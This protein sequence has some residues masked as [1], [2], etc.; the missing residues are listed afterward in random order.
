MNSRQRE[1]RLGKR[2]LA[3]EKEL[4]DLSGKCQSLQGDSQQLRKESQFCDQ[5][6]SSLKVF[7]TK[8]QILSRLFRG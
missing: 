6:K 4:A 3:L 2:V 1:E 5:I 7:T 8:T